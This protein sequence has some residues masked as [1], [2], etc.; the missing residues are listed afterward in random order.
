M[1]YDSCGNIVSKNGIAYSYGDPAWKDILTAYNGQPITYDKQGN[2]TT[3]LGHTLAWEKGRQL[4]S[5]DTNTYTYNANGIRTSKTVNGVKH[6]YTL[7]GTKILCEAWGG[8]TLVPLY[9]NEESVCG[10]I[11]NDEPFYFQKDLQGDIIAIV[12]KNAHTVARY[13]YDAWG[14]CTVVADTSECSAAAV[15]PFRYRGYYFDSETKLFYAESR[16]YSPFTFPTRNFIV[17]TQEE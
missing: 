7:D 3:Y 6:T 9:D 14:A 16:Y 17:R 1:V 8:N 12:D 15:N 13:S 5:F 10:I 2:P 11:Y 4:K